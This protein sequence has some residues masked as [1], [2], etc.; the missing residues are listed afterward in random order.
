MIVADLMTTNPVSVGPSTTLQAAQEVMQHGRFRQLP[1]VDNGSLIGV[2]T[3]RDLRQYLGQLNRVRVDAVM[4]TH[5]FSV[6]PST[7]VEQAAQ[8]LVTKKVGSLPVLDNGKLVGI[9]TASDLLQ[10]LVAILGK[11]GDGSVRID[12]NVAGSGEITA[13]ISL[14]RTFCPVL[15]MGTYSRTATAGE[16]A[17]LYLRIAATGAQR[18]AQTLRDYGFKVLAVHVESELSSK[19]HEIKQ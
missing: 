10:A 1:V 19:A 7:P 16:S 5:L 15:A 17:V 9:I 2:V 18:A 6:Q 8:M 12:L 11:I 4:S 3:D 14:I 13:A